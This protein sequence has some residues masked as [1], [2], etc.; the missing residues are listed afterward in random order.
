MEAAV[1]VL[2]RFFDSPE[3]IVLSHG[4]FPEYADYMQ[5]ELLCILA[6]VYRL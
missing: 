6:A 3:Y 1:L 5:P 4:R 2:H